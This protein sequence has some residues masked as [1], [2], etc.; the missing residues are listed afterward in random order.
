LPVPL[1]PSSSTVVSVPAARWI[2]CET[3]FIAAA[4][5][6]M[7]GAPGLHRCH[8][9]LN[10]AKGGH[11]NHRQLGI[12]VLGCLEHSKSIAGRQ[13]QVGQHDG[14]RRLSQ[15]F[16]RLALIARFDDLM[17]LRLERVAHHHAQ[18][19]LIFD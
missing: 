9:I 6:M 16:D 18:R 12:E 8:G 15:T 11:Y 5:P 7:V 3:C 13:A 14:R 1:S 19:V 10:A 2:A 17:A 4:S